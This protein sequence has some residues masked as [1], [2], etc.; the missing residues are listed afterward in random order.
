MTIV[1][2]AVLMGTGCISSKPGVDAPTDIIHY[3]LGVAVHPEG[4]YAAVVNADFNQAYKNGSVVIIDLA[5][6][7][8][9]AEWTEPIGIF[10]AE[11]AFN[12]AGT[13]MYVTVR[14]EMQPQ[15]D[16]GYEP[17]DVLLAFDVDPE[18]A[19]ATPGDKPFLV[20]GSRR[21]VEV[22]P[23]P[24]GIAIDDD[25]RYIYIT[26]VS[27]GEL[28]VVQDDTGR[29]TDEAEA[30]ELEAGAIIRRCVPINQFCSSTAAAGELCGRCE[31]N[32]E[33][34][35]TD[36]VLAGSA[37]GVFESYE[38]SCLEDP[39]RAG[40]NFCASYCEVDGTETNEAGET[41]RIG[42]PNG[43][44]CERIAPIHVETERKFSRGGNQVSISPLSGTVYV[45][46]RDDSVLGV[47]RPYWSDGIGYQTR[48]EQVSFADG[49]DTRGMAFKDDGSRLFI[50]TRNENI[51]VIDM[52]GIMVIDTELSFEGCSRKQFVGETTSCERNDLVDFIEVDEQPANLAYFGG[53]L[54]VA[55]FG[56]DEIYAIDTRSRQIVGVI[57]VA[58]E[59][60]ISEPGIFREHASPYDIAVYED[61][62]GVWALVS[63][64]TAHEISVISLFDQDG[65]PVNRVE[66]KI[67]NRVKL[68]KE[69]QF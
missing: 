50:A 54:Y 38:D 19:S 37:G 10:G 65:N 1:M 35:S 15:A 61:Q 51:D 6:Y 4:R 58:P 41:V 42:C 33:C 57:D 62:T 8:I 69:D 13:R 63:N 31:E 66:R 67:E 20:P 68:Y 7:R 5:R 28:S 2:S 48:V 3:P 30:A 59:N 24:F 23:D 27:N 44:R 55:L 21:V 22:S 16:Y 11:V 39:R 56:K 29:P 49:Y 47:L 52:P 18:V 12:H 25:D 60:F 43:Y 9:V 14:G 45:S 64:F 36:V 17:P 34:G 26:H 40:R 32:S 46:H 53:Y